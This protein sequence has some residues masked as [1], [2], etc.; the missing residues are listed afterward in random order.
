M[1]PN[2]GRD[3]DDA[4]SASANGRRLMAMNLPKTVAPATIIM[5]I[6]VVRTVSIR[7]F[8]NPSQLS[9]LLIRVITRILAAPTAPASVGVNHPSSRPPMEIRNVTITSK[10]PLPRASKRSFQDDF[11]P[12]GPSDGFLFTRI[13]MV[14][15]YRTIRSMPGTMPAINSFP[16]DC[17][18]EIPYIMKITLGGIRTP[19]APPAA[20][21][22]DESESSYLYDFISGMAIAP[23]VAA[24]AVFEPQIA[25]NIAQ[26]ACVAIAS[27][28]G[29]WPI[30]R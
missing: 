9:C 2:G 7:D 13:L 3:N 4:H 21:L 1:T 15:I 24:V 17:S 18:E 6:A 23:M 8:L 27:P 12:T 22:A 19:R 26:A 10:S 20:T 28:P 25:P 30:M 29:L 16:M 5:I 11:G 14:S